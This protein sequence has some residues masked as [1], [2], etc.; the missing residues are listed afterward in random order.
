MA[1][2]LVHIEWN[3]VYGAKQLSSPR[4]RR[5]R[6]FLTLVLLFG[7][8]VCL[9]ILYVPSGPTAETF[10]NIP[11]GISSQAIASQLSNAGILRNPYAFLFLR[12]VHPGPLHA[13]E[14][15]FDHPVSAIEVY[16][17][18][19]RGDVYTL[20]LAVPE[21]FNLFDIAQAVEHAGLGQ[22]ETF[23]V[24]AQ[25]RTDLI[26]DLFPNAPSLEGFLFPA[27]YR[28][29]RSVTPEQMLTAMTRRFRQAASQL[30]LR[31]NVARTV[32][33]ASL[34]EKE[35]SVDTERPLVAGVFENRLG[36]DMPL[37]TDPA[38]IYAA[39]LEHRYRGTIYRSDLQSLSPYNTYRHPGLTPGPICNPG[40]AALQAALH[41]ARTDFLYFVADSTGHTR[42]SATL[43]EHGQQVAAYR[44]AQQV[45]SPH[46]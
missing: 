22:H 7:A 38:V 4:R 17:R 31:K 19:R 25:E 24:A 27:T 43:Q 23:L 3:G 5:R 10:V 12:L 11:V 16:Q 6:R 2:L 40:I 42:F 44:S 28:F 46:R 32:I 20:T 45:H 9:Y 26:G 34:I 41:P 1:S 8:V 37:E 30:G 36:R 21:G 18:L 13:G 35:V 14:Y 33:L 39:L 29:P 15:R